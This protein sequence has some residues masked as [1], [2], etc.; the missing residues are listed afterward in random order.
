[1]K[2]NCPRCEWQR[3]RDESLSDKGPREINQNLLSDLFDLTYKIYGEFQGTYSSIST[4]Y[5]VDRA[6]VLEVVT[7]ALDKAEKQALDEWR[8]QKRLQKIQ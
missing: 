8:R 1:M 3:V 4:D 7:A 2:N 5:Y 6:K